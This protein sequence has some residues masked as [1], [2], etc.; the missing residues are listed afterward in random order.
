MAGACSPSGQHGRIDPSPP[1]S[2]FPS[3][4]SQNEPSQ[5]VSGVFR[6]AVK[7]DWGSGSP[8][9]IAITA[10]MCKQRRLHPFDVVV[11]TGDNFYHPDG[12]A[13]DQN[14]TSPEACLTRDKSHMWRPSWGNHDIRGPGTRVALGEPRRFYKWSGGSADFFMLNS[15]KIDEEQTRWLDKELGRSTAPVKIVVFHHPAFTDGPHSPDGLVRS[16]WVPIFVRHHVTLVLNGHNH[17]YEHAVVDGVHYVVSGGG[18]EVVYPCIRKEA[19]T[20]R[21]V[22]VHHF[23]LVEISAGH[24]L[25]KAIDKLGTEI[26]SF[27]I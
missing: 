9:Q 6:F 11:T 5:E 13:T 20:L 26:D 14:F 15:N 21:C 22:A 8:D 25:V 27:Q 4:A 17:D 3:A 10:Q 23:L 18:G 24:V 7:G 2:T 16:K 1:P 12:T 19:G